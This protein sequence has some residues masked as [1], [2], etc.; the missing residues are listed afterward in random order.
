[1]SP[2]I[3]IRLLAAQ[4][5]ERL[6]ALVGQGHERA[7][8]ALV[9][10]YRRPLLRYCARLGLSDSRAEDVLQH[11][12]LKAWLA[13]TRGGQ[14]R[15]LKP[16]LYR[17][18][19]NAAI[20]SVRGSREEGA[21]LT[22]ALGASASAA[23]ESELEARLAVR[24]AFTSVAALP[25]MQRDAIVM[26][27]IDGHS[28]NDV[29][30]ALGISDG[31]VRGLLHR[32]RTT[33]RSAAAAIT[34]QSLIAWAARGTGAG[35][36]SAERL[37]E[38][39]GTGGGIGAAAVL[40]KGAVVAA[41]AGVLALGAT[42]A[43]P[44]RHSAPSSK[45]SAR[46]PRALRSAAGARSAVAPAASFESSTQP[47]AHAALA[48]ELLR[49]RRGAPRAGAPGARLIAHG[50]HGAPLELTAGLSQQGG[51]GTGEVAVE[52]NHG[53]RGAGSGTSTEALRSGV[54]AKSSGSD[55][56]GGSSAG[57]SSDGQQAQGSR[58]SGAGDRSGGSGGGGGSGSQQDGD[59][60]LKTGTGSAQPVAQSSEATSEPSAGQS[61]GEASGVNG[62]ATHAGDSPEAQPPPATG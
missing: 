37:S 57:T 19:H 13:L 8:E 14:V 49:L 44:P 21:E 53:D 25:Q 29:A 23:R 32:A 45:H 17:I 46:P 56:G 34:P 27:A 41:S 47:A 24:E 3:S 15:E 5:D 51:N 20:S 38:L 48:V 22:D 40:I 10:R 1:M 36:P 28:H 18:V 58:S 6:V 2:R 55:T 43:R 30:S 35:A 9:L 60:Q 7:F 59:G 39:S 33:L 54:G 52:E 4:S 31:A 50:G 11:A 42:V 62:G 26:S 12:L 61:D 16:W